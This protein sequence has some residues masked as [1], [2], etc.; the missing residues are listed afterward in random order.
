[1]TVTWSER[2]S[3]N[4]KLGNYLMLR[5]HSRLISSRLGNSAIDV[6]NTYMGFGDAPDIQK[7]EVRARSVPKMKHLISFPINKTALIVTVFEL[8]KRDR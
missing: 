2:A 4:Q 7:G 8:Q 5:C 3:P 6:R 1:M